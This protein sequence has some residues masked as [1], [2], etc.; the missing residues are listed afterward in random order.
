[1]QSSA[2][3]KASGVL[4]SKQRFIDAKLTKVAVVAA[5]KPRKWRL[6]G[7]R[8]MGERHSWV[9]CTEIKKTRKWLGNDRFIYGHSPKLT[10]ESK[11]S[12]AP[13]CRDEVSSK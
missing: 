7:G 5:K 2:G 6:V 13:R 9:M 3:V 8:R 1:M 12:G 11:Y 4:T 10:G